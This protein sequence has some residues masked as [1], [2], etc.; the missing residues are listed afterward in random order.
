MANESSNGLVSTKGGANTVYGT[1][2]GSPPHGQAGRGR[3]SL[4]RRARSQAPQTGKPFEN[5]LG[6]M[7]NAGS[8]PSQ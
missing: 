3:H 7:A 5:Q 8:P 2:L 1:E 6:N 4:R